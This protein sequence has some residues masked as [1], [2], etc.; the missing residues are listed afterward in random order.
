MTAHIDHLV[1]GAARLEEGLAW[2]AE[3][4][5]VQV[6][7]GGAHPG[8]GTHNRLMRL[9][10]TCFLEI[11]APD[12]TAPAPGRP[13]WFGLDEQP[14]LPRLLTW[15]VAVPDLDIAIAACPIDMGRATV[16][17]RGTLHWRL[18]VP[19]DGAL[20]DRGVMPSLIEWPDPHPAATMADLGCTLARL[21]LRHPAPDRLRATLSAIGLIDPALHLEA[22]PAPELSALITTPGG[23]RLL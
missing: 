11:I 14:A 10:P 4:L 22:A 23:N 3:R 6:P 19:D 20:V 17:T 5:G 9:S 1:I 12:P 8:M 13:R 21:T 16:M 15:L 18:T 2:V 7:P